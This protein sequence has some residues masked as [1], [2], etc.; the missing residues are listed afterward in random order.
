MLDAL[1]IIINGVWSILCITI[2][3]SDVIHLTLWQFFFGLVFLTLILK[4]TWMQ[5][6][7]RG[8]GK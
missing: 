8:G 7:N 2:P 5:A 3:F 4:Y 6:W 1:Q